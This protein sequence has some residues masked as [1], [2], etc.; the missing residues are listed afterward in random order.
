MVTVNFAAFSN[1]ANFCFVA[2]E[3]RAGSLEEMCLHV[4]VRRRGVGEL[5]A[6]DM[7]G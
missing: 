2:V 4:D 7:K 3:I 6:M 1:P 5:V